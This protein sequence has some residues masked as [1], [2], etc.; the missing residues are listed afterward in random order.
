MFLAQIVA[1]SHVQREGVL[2]A[3]A[4]I[5]AWFRAGIRHL[6]MATFVRQQTLL[7]QKLCGAN[8]ALVDVFGMFYWSVL[9]QRTL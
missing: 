7:V 6:S 3:I 1:F 8:V 9:K 5:T 4:T 2:V